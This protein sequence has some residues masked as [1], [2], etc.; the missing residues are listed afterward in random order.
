MYYDER[1]IHMT[2]EQEALWRYIYRHSGLSKAQ[3]QYLIC[4]T[5]QLQTFR[6][7]SPIPTND[8][9]YIVYD[10]I[11]ESK[12]AH[13]TSGVV[14]N[15]EMFSGELFPI[16][17]VYMDYCSHER[18]FRRRRMHPIAATA[19]VRLYAIPTETLK[20]L[21]TNPGMFVLR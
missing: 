20:A 1:E 5:L 4:P 17:N 3:F 11:V 9:V 14:Q 2:E 16:E 21:S 8:W 13:L 19:T 7:G 6:K 18:I 15:V 10:G 12:V